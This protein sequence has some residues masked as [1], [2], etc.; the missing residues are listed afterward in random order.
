MSAPPEQRNV[1]SEALIQEALVGE[2][3]INGGYVVLVADEDMRYLAASDAACELLG[4]SR[5]ELLDLTV[6]DVVVDAHAERLYDE[7]KRERKQRGTITLRRKDGTSVE[8]DYDARETNVAGSLYYV[9]VISPLAP[10]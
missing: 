7:F 8:A 3:V 2:A 9:S 6:P 4:Y 5:Q 10:A 1:H